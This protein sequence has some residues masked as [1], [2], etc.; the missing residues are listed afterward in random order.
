MLVLRRKVG[1]RIRIGDT[2]H[3]S[4]LAIEGERVKLGVEAPPHVPIVREELLRTTHKSGTM[5]G[6]GTV[7]SQSNDV[8]ST[9]TPS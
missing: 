2:I 3:L 6:Q 7:A 8:M 5:E 1:E 9:R 4:I